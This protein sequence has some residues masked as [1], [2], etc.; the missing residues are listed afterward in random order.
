MQAD[1]NEDN[2]L[3]LQEMLNHEFAFYN[4]VY[5]DGHV[6]DDDDDDDDDHDEL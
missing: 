3:T 6:E 2:K 4:T 1:D 5:A